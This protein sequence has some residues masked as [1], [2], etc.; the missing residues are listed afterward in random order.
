V[1]NLEKQYSFLGMNNEKLISNSIKAI[2]KNNNNSDLKLS[3]IA[4][5]YLEQASANTK[6]IIFGLML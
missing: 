1:N 5:N 6:L 4:V 2:F 3:Q